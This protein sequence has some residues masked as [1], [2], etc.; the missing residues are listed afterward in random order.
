MYLGQTDPEA[1]MSKRLI[2]S[3]SSQHQ[4]MNK[5]CYES[6]TVTKYRMLTFLFFSISLL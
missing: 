1:E 5:K 2:I 3:Y 6:P 4:S